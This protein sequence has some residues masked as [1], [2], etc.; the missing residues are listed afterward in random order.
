MWRFRRK[1][2]MRIIA[3]RALECA[4]RLT[5][6][7]CFYQFCCCCLAQKMVY[8]RIMSRNMCCRLE[9]N[10]KSRTIL[11]ARASVCFS[12]RRPC[13]SALIHS[14]HSRHV[15]KFVHNTAEP[16]RWHLAEWASVSVSALTQHTESELAP[17]TTA[18]N[19]L[20]VCVWNRFN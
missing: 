16:A 15:V 4:P 2:L 6:S 3:T 8:S 11:S 1:I 13:W 5:R 10:K 19:C 18:K 9:P 12:A 17:G 20:C 14:T 7:L